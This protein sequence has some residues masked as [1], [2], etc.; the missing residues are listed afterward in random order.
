MFYYFTTADFFTHGTIEV[1]INNSFVAYED[2]S[3]NTEG[4]TQIKS[5]YSIMGHE[6]RVLTSYIKKVNGRHLN[7]EGISET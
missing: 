4:I 1:I 2:V 5:T 6:M 3:D 7:L